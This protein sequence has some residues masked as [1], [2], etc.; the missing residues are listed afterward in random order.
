MTVEL[1]T[2]PLHCD[3]KPFPRQAAWHCQWQA[4]RAH[5]RK[6]LLGSTKSAPFHTNI[7]ACMLHLTR[8]TLFG[9]SSTTLPCQLRTRRTVCAPL[10]QR[11]SAVSCTMS[12]LSTRDELTQSSMYPHSIQSLTPGEATGTEK[13]R[14]GR[15]NRMIVQLA[16]PISPFSPVPSHGHP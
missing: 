10:A 6:E 4:S 2:L 13:H 12:S 8:S 7:S 9:R 16:Y 14:L 5:P 3:H 1:P 15:V 11:R